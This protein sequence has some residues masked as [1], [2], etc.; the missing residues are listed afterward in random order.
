M[1]K[2]KK[3]VWLF[4]LQRKDIKRTAVL[5]LLE[6]LFKTFSS[7]LVH[8]RVKHRCS[9][10]LHDTEQLG[11]ACPIISSKLCS[12]KERWSGYWC[13]GTFYNFPQKKKIHFTIAILETSALRRSVDFAAAVLGVVV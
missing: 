13:C 9:V 10:Q 5:L 12:Q 1:K 6:L 7:I 11:Q 3:C 4:D 2:D 8:C